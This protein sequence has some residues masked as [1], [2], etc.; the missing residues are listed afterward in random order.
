MHKLIKKNQEQKLYLGGVSVPPD[1]FQCKASCESYHAE[2]INTHSACPLD[3]VLENIFLNFFLI[4][5]I[6]CSDSC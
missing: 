6:L 2:S 1:C 3:S 4:V 5:L